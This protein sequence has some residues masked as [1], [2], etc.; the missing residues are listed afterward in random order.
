MLNDVPE[1]PGGYPTGDIASQLYDELDFQR[2]VQ[3]YVWAVP[4][5]NSV[6]F[7]RA[8]REGGVS[9]SEPTLLVFD[10]ALTADQV[11]MTANAEVIY[12]FSAF[13]LVATGPL[14]VDVPAGALGGFTDMWQRAVE[15]V[16]IGPSANGARFVVLH[17]P[18]VEVEVPDD[19]II[20]RTKT[21]TLL[22][23]ARGILVPGHGPEAFVDLVSR[24]RIYPLAAAS[25]PPDT[26]VVLNG[27]RPFDSDWPKD[28]RYFECLAEGLDHVV[29]EEQDKVMYAMLEPLGI[30]H[31]APFQP[32]AR[33]AGIFDRAAQL[34]GAIVST[35]A[36]ANRRRDTRPLWPDR[37]WEQISYTS[38]PDSATDTMIEL[39]QRTQWYQLVMNLRYGYGA[40][41]VPGTGTWYCSTYHDSN[42]DYLDGSGTY[43]LTL[44]EPPPAKQFWSIT[45]YDNRTRSMIDNDQH[46]AGISTYTNPVVDDDGA[47]TLRFGPEAPDDNSDNWIQTIP[48]QGFFV[49]F[50][51]YGPLEPVF[52]GTWKLDDLQRL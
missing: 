20:V 49:M 15:D 44:H 4:L 33:V 36:F 46:R 5:V 25:S 3:A 52:E 9:L 2:A 6:G 16:G 42:G 29:V 35:M 41:V 14:V 50:R 32:D 22:F 8:L 1:L 18:G 27:D 11:F 21:P 43:Q 48:G 39:D 10:R 37:T 23:F 34:G 47:I 13:D 17:P 51:L 40:H 28:A 31:G 30:S 7:V 45:I 12:A 24:I 19:A 38:N 26:R